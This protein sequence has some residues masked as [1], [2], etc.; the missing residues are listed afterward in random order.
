MIIG[1]ALLFLAA[2]TLAGVFLRFLRTHYP[3]VWK[4]LGEPG[5]FRNNNLATHIRISKYLLTG[6]YRTLPHKG[7]VWIFDCV[8]I[9]EFLVLLSFLYFCVSTAVFLFRTLF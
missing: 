5:L 3:A 7:L 4:E 2:I 6:K 8:R 9:V 1:A